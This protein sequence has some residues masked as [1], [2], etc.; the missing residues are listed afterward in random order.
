[1]DTAELAINKLIILSI[2]NKI[3][4]VT[5][6]QLTTLSLETLYMDY[7]DFVTA[8][9]ELCRDHM[10]TES[11]RKG[12]ETLDA[13]GRPV[14]RCDLTPAGAAV[15]N[16][17]ESRIPLPIRSYLAQACSGWQ[18]DMRMQN[19]LTAASEPDGNGFYQVRLK[20]HDGMKDVVDLRLTIPDKGMAQQIC[21]RWKRHP[22]LV[23]LGLLSL[24]TGE[25]AIGMDEQ[26]TESTFE[27]FQTD[28]EL[29]SND[30]SAV[31][32]NQQTLF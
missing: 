31:D 10:A 17:L 5:L 15:L 7:F 6:N 12:E 18:K 22:Q 13:V 9:E 24:L 1:M 19:T 4:G 3:Q 29:S 25:T 14:T 32:P 16:T 26:L 8:Y 21:D 28:L 2:L 23:Y 30:I 20:Q 27:P 11:V